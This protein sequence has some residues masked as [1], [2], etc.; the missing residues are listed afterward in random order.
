MH[1]FSTDKQERNSL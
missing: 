1:Y